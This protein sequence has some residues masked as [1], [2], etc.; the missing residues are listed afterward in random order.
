[1]YEKNWIDIVG[2]KKGSESNVKLS[3]HIPS[4]PVRILDAPDMLDD[5]Y[6]N[7]LSWSSTNVLAVALSQVVYLWDASSGKW[8]E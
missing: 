3:R 8:H 1:M 2:S 6:L 5:Y 4:A 7:L